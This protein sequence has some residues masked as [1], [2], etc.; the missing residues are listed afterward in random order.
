LGSMR[1]SPAM[2][3]RTTFGIVTDPSASW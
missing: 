2:Y 1:S 3:G